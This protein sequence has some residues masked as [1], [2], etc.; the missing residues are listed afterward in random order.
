[1]LSRFFLKPAI[2]SLIFFFLFAFR[3]WARPHSSVV[4]FVLGFQIF[5]FFF[6]FFLLFVGDEVFVL[7]PERKSVP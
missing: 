5:L 6:F 7:F 1:M 2:S 4:V 3:D